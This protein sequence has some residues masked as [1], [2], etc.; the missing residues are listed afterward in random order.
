MRD[1]IPG[2]RVTV[3]EGRRKSVGETEWREGEKQE[4]TRVVIGTRMIEGRGC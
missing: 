3:M 4:M 1:A 2:R